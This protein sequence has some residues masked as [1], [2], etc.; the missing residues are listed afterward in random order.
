MP[1]AYIIHMLGG[2]VAI[3]A[4]FIALFST[5]GAPLHR[6]IGMVFVYAMFTLT[7]TGVGIAAYKGDAGTVVGGS[8]A[9]YLVAT[10]FIT[11]RPATARWRKAL[12]GASAIGMFVVV[13]S[14]TRAIMTIDRPS[15][16]VGYLVFCTIALL[17][18]WGDV[19]VLRGA[20]LSAAPR[21]RR[22]LWRLSIGLWIA[23]ASFFLG[24]RRRVLKVLPDAIVST[25][26]V[27]IPVLLV[28]VVMVYWLWRLRS[29][30]PLRGVVL[31]QP[32]S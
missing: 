1:P 23:T 26:T 11:V 25:A 27:T 6:R 8:L 2:A 13:L 21:L 3:V 15:A 4:G 30:A 9:T 5:K 28:L 12:L 19:R 24:P 7:L 14:A 16:A 17:A 31:T 20:A 18:V 29:K 10:G 22:H 32:V